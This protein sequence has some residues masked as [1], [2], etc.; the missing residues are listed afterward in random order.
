MFT[1][2]RLGLCLHSFSLILRS[3]LIH[4]PAACLLH[5]YILRV[6]I[7]PAK[8]CTYVHVVCRYQSSL[9]LST[10]TYGRYCTLKLHYQ[11]P[12]CGGN[13]LSVLLFSVLHDTQ[14]Y[15]VHDSV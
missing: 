14:S 3:I 12:S 2:S 8:G 6:F 5:I 7:A 15:S 1:Q 13:C 9:D 4:T 11:H 10:K